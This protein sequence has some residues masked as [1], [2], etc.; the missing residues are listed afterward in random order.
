MC[1]MVS[2][3]PYASAYEQAPIKADGRVVARMLVRMSKLPLKQMGSGSPY[4]SAYEQAPI[5][6]D[7]EW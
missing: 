5:E 4:A 7:G 1:P 2:G 3:N 6:A